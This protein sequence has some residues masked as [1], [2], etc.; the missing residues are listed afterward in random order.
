[1]EITEAKFKQILAEQLTEQRTEY[2]HYM[3]IIK[4]DIDSKFQLI[5][6]QLA[7]QGEQLA[8][9]TEMISSLMEDMS[10]VKSDL[11]IVKSELKRKVYYDE[12]EAL[13]KRVS[14]LESKN[15]K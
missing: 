14:L 9:H 11:Q 5:G 2:Q 3:G 13:E 4:E 15:R 10:I 6:E 12:F 1:M 7:S 8:S